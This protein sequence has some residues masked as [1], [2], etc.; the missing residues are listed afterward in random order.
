MR[1]DVIGAKRSFFL[2]LPASSSSFVLMTVVT[3]ILPPSAPP[4]QVR[5]LKPLD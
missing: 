4:V 3:H 5:N 2:F 1:H